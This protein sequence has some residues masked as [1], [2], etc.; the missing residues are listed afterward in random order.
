MGTQPGWAISKNSKTWVPGSWEPGRIGFYDAMI[1]NATL[2]L[3]ALSRGFD[4]VGPSHNPNRPSTGT[5][6]TMEAAFPMEIWGWFILIPAGILATSLIFR[7]HISVWLGHGLLAIIYFA[8]AIALGSEF[9]VRPWW[10]GIRSATT[11]ILP[12]VLHALICIRT[13]WR[14]PVLIQV[15]NKE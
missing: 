5:F 4:Y 9:V 14:P 6:D 7:V 11:L 12:T 3:V 10:D 15:P 8:L 2:V 13:G 1:I